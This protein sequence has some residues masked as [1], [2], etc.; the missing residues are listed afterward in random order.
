MLVTE[1]DS[2]ELATQIAEKAIAAAFVSNAIFNS[3]L[4]LS[5]NML[6]SC[7]N[8]IQLI[9]HMPLL[10]LY[11]PANA[12]KFNAPLTKIANFD[13]LDYYELQ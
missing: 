10:S 13:I 9:V 4:Q 1:V 12:I 2:L 8:A 5:L 6:W 7:L 3:L 11:Y